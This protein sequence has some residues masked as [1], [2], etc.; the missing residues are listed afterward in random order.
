MK[1]GLFA[2]LLFAVALVTFGLSAR[3]AGTGNLVV[4][5][6]SWTENYENLGSWAWGDTA[7][8]RLADGMDEFGAYFEFNNVAVGT[9]VGFIAVTWIGSEG[10]DWNKKLTDDI[11]IPSDTIIENETVH[12][13]VFEGKLG[14]GNAGVYVAD[15]TKHNALVVYFDPSGSYSETLGIHGWGWEYENDPEIGASQWGTPT[16]IFSV[17][18]RNEAGIDVWAAMLSANE[19]WAGFLMYGGDDATKKT[20]DINDT[21]FITNLEDGAV[22]FAYIVNA[23][24]AV[25]SNE[26]VFTTPQA[27][28][29]AAFSFKLMGYDPEKMSGTY[30]IDKNTVVVETSASVASPY[31]AAETPAE[32]EAALEAIKTWFTIKDGSGSE[33]AIE[34]VDFGRSF[35]TLKTFVV[36]LVGNGL[37]NTK[38][39]TVEFDTNYPEALAEAKMI[40]VTINVTVPDNTPDDAIISLGASFGGWNPGDVNWA[41]TKTATNQYSITFDLEVIE[42]VTAFEYKWTQGSWDIGENLAD[43][44]RKFELSNDM[45]EVIFDDVIL[46]WDKDADAANT[47]YAATNRTV[48]LPTKASASIE[49][50][51]DREDPFLTFIS[52]LTF[53]GAAESARVIEVPWGEKFD[54]TL[55]PRFAV[56]DD[57]DGDLTSY[58]Y[59]PK[60]E[61]S[62]IDTS[63]EGDY[64]IMLRVVDTWGNVT[65]ETFI[66][67]VVKGE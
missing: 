56:T 11:F 38:D 42:A 35:E 45:T 40:Q 15:P 66:F 31:F 20:G 27:F 51:L 49:L 47:K 37:D 55:F 21:N 57:R 4:H 43:G 2:I 32:Q 16:R 53:V 50:E 65:E 44:N 17:A 54:Q 18:G 28:N 59:V 46:A 5:F 36:I 48:F 12:V 26:N 19:D 7:S 52:P 41:A 6:Q 9:E 22:N 34:R 23:G 13:Y 14:N 67:R 58:V 3:A 62:V 25:T 60:G 8:G 39:Y 33:V 1:K 24:D 10:P 64:T 29:E 61:F 63:E 30:A